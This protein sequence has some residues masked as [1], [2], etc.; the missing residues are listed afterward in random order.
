MSET[1]LA[2]ILV[3]LFGVFAMLAW[4]VYELRKTNSSG[5]TGKKSVDE[6]NK[7]YTEVAEEDVLHLFNTQF[8]EELRNRGRLRFE[9]VI[10]ENAMFLKQDLDLTISQLNEHLKKEISAHLEG[11]FANYAK[12][13][14][15]AQE[16]ALT[17]LRKTAAEVEQQ[18]TSLSEA[19]KKEVDD[20][21][22]AILK[23]YEDNMSQ[24]IEH[25]VQGALGDQF[26]LRTQL[27]FILEQMETNKED[28]IRDMRL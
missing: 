3:G 16:L 24:I 22:V 20:R 21:E 7:A 18:R 14:N 17:S 2:S 9:S 4:L 1:W 8:R 25:Y 12:A 10:N 6:L 27:P 15:D 5:K 13:M 26:D 19:L 28:I 11:E 23:V